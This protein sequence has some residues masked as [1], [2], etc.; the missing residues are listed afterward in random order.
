MVVF[1][2]SPPLKPVMP[3]DPGHE[4]KGNWHGLVVKHAPYS[5]W[6]QW[7]GALDDWHQPMQRGVTTAAGWSFDGLLRLSAL[8]PLNQGLIVVVDACADL[9]ESDL[10]HDTV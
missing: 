3:S 1:P 5:I 8:Q 7:R 10:L 4:F 2:A 9:F 6:S